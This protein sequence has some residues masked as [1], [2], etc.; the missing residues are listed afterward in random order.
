MRIVAGRHRGRRL[1]APAGM[2]VRPTADRTREALFNILTQGKLP[3]RAP[4]GGQ[5]VGGQGVAEQ[6][7]KGQGAERR[8]NPLAGAR[9]LDAF[10]GSGALGLETLSRGAAFVTFMENQAAALAACRNNIALLEETARSEALR[11]DVLRPP[12]APAP[13]DLVLMDPPYNQGLA[14]PALAALEAAGW[15]APGALGVVELM[16]KE[17]FAPP[18]GFE[19]L[20]ERK[21]G[22]ARLV[23]LRAP[24]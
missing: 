9:A 4:V 13:C 20:D 23:F 21:Y 12:P 5:G 15:L 22:K 8:G 18:E 3:W 7:V 6:G 17:P 16:A 11:C 1:E 14:S 24:G 2:A 10:A 19:T